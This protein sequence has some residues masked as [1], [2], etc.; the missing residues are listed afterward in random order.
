M[1]VEVGHGATDQVVV[2]RWRGNEHAHLRVDVL[3]AVALV[4]APP[5]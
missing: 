4:L 1:A 3:V 2:G 5:L